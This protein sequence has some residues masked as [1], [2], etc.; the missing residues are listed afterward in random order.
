MIRSRTLRR[1]SVRRRRRRVSTTPPIRPPS[2]S[3]CRRRPPHRDSRWAPPPRYRPVPRISRRQR[4]RPHRGP[5]S[6]TRPRTTARAPRQPRVPR[7]PSTVR[8]PRTRPLRAPSSTGSSP[9]RNRRPRRPGMACPPSPGRRPRHPVSPPSPPPLR[10]AIQALRSATTPHR[11]PPRVSVLPWGIRRPARRH[12]AS[13]VRLRLGRVRPAVRPR[14]ARRHGRR[15]AL[16]DLGPLPHR[17]RR[18]RPPTTCSRGSASCW[19][20]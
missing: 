6:T 20:R 8:T 3:R 9:L 7:P 5:F 2:R 13:T 10:K 12:R 1:D 17:R 11:P 19:S 14:R 15:A 16:A 4:S 18:A